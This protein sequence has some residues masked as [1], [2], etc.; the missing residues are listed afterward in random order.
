MRYLLSFLFICTFTAIAIARNNSAAIK[1]TI[2]AA[3]TAENISALALPDSVNI[4]Q[5]VAKQINAIKEKQIRK[6]KNQIIVT[7]LNNETSNP[8]TKK[9]SDNLLNNFIQKTVTPFLNKVNNAFF[10]SNE[11][12]VKVIILGFAS[13]ITLLV[14][15]VR[16]KIIKR[17]Y[18]KK[19]GLKDNIRLLREEKIVKKAD[20][21]LKGVRNKLV[22]NTISYRSTQT[23]ISEV[24][25]N[26]NIATGEV[27][28]AAKLKS[29][30]LN[31]SRL[32][33]I[34]KNMS[35]RIF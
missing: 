5:M 29:Y 32:S 11:I 21:R 34:Y 18:L 31:K 35:W 30:E 7:N 15:F 9:S 23:G 27:L 33:R 20:T 26:M 25:K 14:V 3:G 4:R 8:V 28:L 12:F 24:A 1:R 17:K 6:N 19:N 2:P 13:I 16:R 10:N 22:N